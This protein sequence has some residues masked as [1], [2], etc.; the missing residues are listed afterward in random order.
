M[1]REKCDFCKSWKDDV[2]PCS[3]GNENRCPD[4]RKNSK[5]NHPQWQQQKQHKSP[6]ISQPLEFLSHREGDTQR[7]TLRQR[8]AIITL[9]QD[10]QQIDEICAK[11]GCSKPTVYRWLNHYEATGELYD[12]LRGED[13]TL[14][15]ATVDKIVH[16]AKD[17]KFTTP[18]GT[19]SHIFSLSPPSL[20]SSFSFFPSQKSSTR[21][22]FPVLLVPSVVDW[23]IMVYMVVSLKQRIIIQKHSCNNE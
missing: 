15:A 9:R 22:I 7:L 5:H 14:D 17:T 1:P 20:T 10:G 4:C 11:V 12:D 8:D 13:R 21:L 6:S 2:K 19:T 23:T 3:S 18:K 16:L